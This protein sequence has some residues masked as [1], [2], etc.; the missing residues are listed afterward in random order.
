[1][2]RKETEK[3]NYLNLMQDH[4]NYSPTG[5]WQQWMLT[6]WLKHM[7]VFMKQ[8]IAQL[9]GGTFA[10]IMSLD[11]PKTPSNWSDNSVLQT[12]Y[13][14]QQPPPS[15]AQIHSSCVTANSLGWSLLRDGA[16]KMAIKS[17]DWEYC[18]TLFVYELAC[19]SSD[20]QINYCICSAIS[21]KI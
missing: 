16:T 18:L 20:S 6:E 3:Q 8:W 17:L 9:V 12:E 5:C 4:K 1:M 7:F 2:K 10:M 15:T 19:T 11:E 13:P 14:E 21:V